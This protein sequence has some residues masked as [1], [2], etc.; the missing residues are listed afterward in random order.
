MRDALKSYHIMGKPPALSRRE[1]E[2][3]DI[4]Y[5][6]GEASVTDVQEGLDDAP[7]GMAIRRL[8]SIME[9]KGH[10]RRTKDGR[11]HLY[12][13]ARAKKKVGMEALRHVLDT[14]FEGS[15]DD[16]LALHLTEGDTDVTDEQLRRMKRL[17]EEARKKGR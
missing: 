15:V 16:A 9:E 2:I 10:V 8:L 13:P 3:M 7:T 4:L 17:I 1:R 5:A 14:F 6:K 12:R 11:K